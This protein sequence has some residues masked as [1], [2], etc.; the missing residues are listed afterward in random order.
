MKCQTNRPGMECFLMSP[1]G[2]RANGGHCHP[3]V[4][5]CEGCV[6]VFK[7]L[8]CLAATHPELRWQDGRCNLATHLVDQPKR[9]E[10]RINTGKAY[11]RAHAAPEGEKKEKESK[12]K[13]RTKKKSKKTSR[14]KG[15]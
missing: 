10:R 6:R 5:A 1:K 7:G 2:C 12:Y 3:I 14:G 11:K 9:E 8:L 15:R 13:E 4:A